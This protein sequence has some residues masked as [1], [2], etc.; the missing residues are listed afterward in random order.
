MIPPMIMGPKTGP[1]PRGSILLAGIRPATGTAAIVMDTGM[2]TTTHTITPRY[3]PTPKA[4][5]CWA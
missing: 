2:D 4:R 3:R 5:D 1:E